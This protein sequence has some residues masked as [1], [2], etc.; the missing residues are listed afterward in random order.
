MHISEWMERVNLRKEIQEVYL[1][2]FLFKLAVSMVAIFLPLYILDLGYSPQHVFAF[3]LIYYII[4]ILFSFPNGYVASR[5]GYKHTSLLS[6]PFILIFYLLL[7]TEPTVVQLYLIAIIG[8]LGFNMYWAGMNPEI[9]TSSHSKNREEETGYFYSMPTIATMISPLVGGLILA[10]YNFQILFL[11]TAIFIAGSFAPFLFSKEHHDGMEMNVGSF[12]KKD[13]FT[14]FMTYFGKGFNSIGRK[15]LWPLYLAIVIQASVSIGGAG[16]LMALG[17]AVA[18]IALGKATNDNNR[19]KV[20]LSGTCVAIISY[21]LMIQVTSAV[22]ALIVSFINGLGRT[23]MN[24][25][26]YSRALDRAEEEDLVEYLAFREVSLS[27]GRI[28][29]IILLAGLFVIFQNNF[30]LSF[31]VLAASMLIIGY[32][33]RKV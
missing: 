31:I 27:I 18:S 17:A 8:G 6:S 13:H 29:T 33:G 4:Y 32:F 22:P 3:F 28:V 16:S 14:D 15:V 26:I 25:P 23:A 5:I 9:A 30:T 12:L 19:T 7:R 1:H 20:L 21:L 2:S 24:I 11:F 10:L